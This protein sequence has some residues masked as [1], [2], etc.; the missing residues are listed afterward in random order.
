MT[1]QAAILLSAIVGCITFAA[2]NYYLT[3]GN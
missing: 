3:R 2:G 1:P